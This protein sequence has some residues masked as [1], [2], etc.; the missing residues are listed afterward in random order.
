MPSGGDNCCEDSEGNSKQEV[1]HAEDN[2]IL[3]AAKE[4]VSLRFATVYLTHAP[5]LRCAA[6]LA[7]LEVSRVVYSESYRCDSGVRYLEKHGISAEC[8]RH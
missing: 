2:A 8:I 3:A 1:Q 6:K 5:C 4:G 7:T